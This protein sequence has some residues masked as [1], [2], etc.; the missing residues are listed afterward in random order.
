MTDCDHGHQILTYATLFYAVCTRYHYHQQHHHHQFILY[1]YIM[2]KMQQQWYTYKYNY[3]IKISFPYFPS[4]DNN[5]IRKNFLHGMLFR[6][7]YY[8]CLYFI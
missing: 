4:E 7:I 2:Q 8:S 5:L 6:D 1:Y 3:K